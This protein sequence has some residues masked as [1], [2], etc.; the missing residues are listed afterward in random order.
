LTFLPA[1]QTPPHRLGVEHFPKTFGGGRIIECFDD[2]SPRQQTPVMPSG[3]ASFP[4][5]RQ[6]RLESN[7][8]QNTHALFEF[9]RAGFSQLLLPLGKDFWGYAPVYFCY[10]HGS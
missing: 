1:D 5:R 9:V 4:R 6:V 3:A 7:D 10:N 2:K 8:N